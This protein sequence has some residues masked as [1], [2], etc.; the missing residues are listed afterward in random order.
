MVLGGVGYNR[1]INKKRGESHD[2]KTSFPYQW[3]FRTNSG[4]SDS[5]IGCLLIGRGMGS[6]R[7]YFGG[8]GC[9]GS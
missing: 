8:I 4:I 1:D 9:F 7:G 5:R 6:L 3:L 2:G